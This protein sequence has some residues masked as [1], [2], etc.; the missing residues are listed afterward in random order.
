M[1]KQKLNLI[2]DWEV[3][4][5]KYTVKYFIGSKK[6]DTSL[7]MD[8][9]NNTKYISERLNLCN[10]METLLRR[11]SKHFEIDEIADFIIK[12]NLIEE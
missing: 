4:F 8:T 2:N 1:K 7:R 10:K 6:H 5:D 11:N 12:N 9:N 3:I